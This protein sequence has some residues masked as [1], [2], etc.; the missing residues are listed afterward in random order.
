MITR[1]LFDKVCDEM[2]QY[3]MYEEGSRKLHAR[4][5]TESCRICLGP[6][7]SHHKNHGLLNIIGTLFL[8]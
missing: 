4:A 5:N 7:G 3:L 8:L 1:L 2:A 6:G